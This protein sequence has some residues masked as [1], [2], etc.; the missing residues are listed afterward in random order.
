M[1][2]AEGRREQ[3]NGEVGVKWNWMPGSAFAGMKGWEK[4]SS[5]TKEVKITSALFADDTTIVG[6]KGEINEG[7]ERIK[8]VMNKWEERNNDDKEEVLEFGTEEGKG[9]RVLGSW[10]GAKRT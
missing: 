8:S 3:G 4:G 10:M 2:S 9:I 7:V 5:E 6:T 1:R